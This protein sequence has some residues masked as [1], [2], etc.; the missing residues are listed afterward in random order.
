MA[1]IIN[2]DFDLT[3]RKEKVKSSIVI[4]NKTHQIIT[5]FLRVYSDI[6]RRRTT[7]RNQTEEQTDI[8][9]AMLIFSASGLDSAVKQ[10]INDALETIV[11]NNEGAQL[12][13]KSFLRRA[14]KDDDS[15]NINVLA[16]LFST[17]SP[18]DKGLKMLK[19]ELTSNSLQS[20]EQL[21]MVG[22]YFDIK[23]TDITNDVQ[24]LKK[25]FDARNEIIHEMDIV[26]ITSIRR[27]RGRPMQTMCEYTNLMLKTADNFIVSTESKLY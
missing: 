24:L 17:P 27:R 22:S 16:D 19:H 2:I 1:N 12:Q 13:M 7:Q 23:S 4:L 20:T 26:N 9:R 3:G 10:L 21:L 6:G 15:I 18:W 14:L 5:R 11:K 25:A 8:L